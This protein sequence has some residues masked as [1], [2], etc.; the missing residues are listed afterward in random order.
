MEYRIAIEQGL[1]AGD[2]HYRRASSRGTP[3][4]PGRRAPVVLFS[5]SPTL[6]IR[7]AQRA[8]RKRATGMICEP[9]AGE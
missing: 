9:G 2:C 4:L 6:L 3:R 8:R 1:I 5:M 7:K